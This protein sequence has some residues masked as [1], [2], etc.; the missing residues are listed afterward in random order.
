MSPHKIILLVAFILNT[1]M[2][3]QNCIQMRHNIKFAGRLERI[4]KRL[5][6]KE[7][8]LDL[9]VKQVKLVAKTHA[10]SAEI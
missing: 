10:T 4:R 9:L 8:K 3:I 1:Y 6:F 7:A 2:I 5:A